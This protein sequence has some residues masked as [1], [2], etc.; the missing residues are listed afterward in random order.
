MISRFLFPALLVLF[1]CSCGNSG[2]GNKGKNRKVD[3]THK[4]NIETEQKAGLIKTYELIKSR[5]SQYDDS[6]CRV[7]DSVVFC[8]YKGVIDLAD[9]TGRSRSRITDLNCEYL[10]DKVYVLPRN[11]NRWFVVWQ[12]TDQQGQKTNLGVYTKGENKANWRLTFPYTNLGPPVV[13]G[14]MCYFTT[15]G[16]VGKVD[17]TNGKLQWKIDSLFNPYKWSYKKFALPLVFEDK[18]V[19]IDLPEPG[20][21]E[22]RDT[23]VLDPATGKRKS[24]QKKAGKSK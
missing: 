17:I 7:G 8:S 5:K 11:N 1:F 23:L 10:V 13:D 14:D 21:R 15:M 6:R 9:S 4:R 18:V 3:T 12:E 2:G 16:M 24:N 19:F 20:R 22:K